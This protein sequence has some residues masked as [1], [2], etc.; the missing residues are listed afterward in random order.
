MAGSIGQ[1]A[2]LSSDWPSS[3]GWGPKALEHQV[4]SM[5]TYQAKIYGGNSSKD[6]E[7]AGSW[8]SD[9]LAGAKA[10]AANATDQLWVI[11]TNIA[12]GNDAEWPN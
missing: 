1:A 2:A 10:N 7:A 3:A 9:G 5:P 4:L 11:L 8:S 6:P 12:T